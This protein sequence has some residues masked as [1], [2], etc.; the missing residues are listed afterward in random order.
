MT[1]EIKEEHEVKLRLQDKFTIQYHQLDFFSEG[2]QSGLDTS[3]CE[4]ESEQFAQQLMLAI[5]DHLSRRNL[6]DIIKDCEK[7]LKEWGQ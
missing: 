3:D 6:A 1:W 7:T 4:K 2:F 5:G